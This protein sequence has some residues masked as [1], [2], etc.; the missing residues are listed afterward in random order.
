MESEQAQNVPQGQTIDFTN[1]LI[2]FISKSR[3]SVKLSDTFRQGF[4]PL[5]GPCVMAMKS[6]LVSKI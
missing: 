5:A 1:K 6:H 4:F 2:L 3:G